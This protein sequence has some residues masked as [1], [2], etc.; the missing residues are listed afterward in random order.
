MTLQDII[1]SQPLEGKPGLDPLFASSLSTEMEQVF[2]AIRAYASIVE[3]YQEGGHFGMDGSIMCD[4]RNLIQWHLMSLLP[5]SQLGP[6]FLQSH[7]IYEACRISAM[8]FGV[9]VTF[10]L[11]PETAPLST[12]AKLLQIELQQH[13]QNIAWSSLAAVRVL[14]WAFTLGGIAA[15]G[16]H[17]REWFVAELKQLA[18]LHRLNTWDDLKPILKTVLWLDCACDSAGKKLWNEVINTTNLL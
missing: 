8:I 13:D 16:T 1:S 10:P 6:V 5:A 7:P 12:L 14:F 18:L 3:T 11:P 9:G 2:Q 15:T 17:N 4:Q